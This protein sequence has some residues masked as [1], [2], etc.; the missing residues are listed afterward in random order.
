MSIRHVKHEYWETSDG[1]QHSSQEEAG[2]HEIH[3]L[4]CEVLEEQDVLHTE[5]LMT[6][7]RALCKHP[8]LLIVRAQ[9][10]HPK[11]GM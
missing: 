3:L 1:A 6:I 4:V 10:A 11:V 5:G 2:A 8:Y 9:P 7:A